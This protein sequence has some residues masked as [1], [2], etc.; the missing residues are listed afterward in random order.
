VTR[1]FRLAV[2]GD[3][4]D[5]VDVP[6]RALALLVGIAAAGAGA[7]AA[8]PTPPPEVPSG[9]RARA[10]AGTHPTGVLANVAKRSAAQQLEVACGHALEVLAFELGELDAVGGVADVEVEDG[11]DEGE[12]AGLAG[13]AADHLGA[14]LDLVQ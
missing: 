2:V 9:H 10:V 14:P 7:V 1:A 13:E 6:E 3:D 5:A 4:H 11:P 8:Q 12:A